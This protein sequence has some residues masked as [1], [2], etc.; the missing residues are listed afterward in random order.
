MFMMILDVA[1]ESRF[2]CFFNL[3]LSLINC[4]FSLPDGTEI[5]SVD[6]FT[7]SQSSDDFVI[8]I[9]IIKVC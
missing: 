7:R 9:T 2:L 8:G 1:Y 5:V 3:F 6:A 4:K